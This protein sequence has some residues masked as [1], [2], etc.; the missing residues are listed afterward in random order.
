VI[1]YHASQEQF[2]PSELLQYAI[3]AEKAGFEAIHS[4]DHFHPWSKRQGNSGFTFAWVAA[5]MQA[6]TIPFGMICSPGQRYH[7]AIVAQAA[8][9]IEEMFPGRF[10]LELGSGEA[11]NEIITGDP[12]PN[13]Q[14]RN[15]RLLECNDIIRRLWN[16]ETVSYDGLVKI[17]EATLY[18]LPLKAPPLIGA[19]LS[20]AT[21]SWLG[22]WTDGLITTADSP[23]QAREILTAFRKG[24]GEGK[25]TYFKLQLSY[26]RS[27]ESA[28][29]G[30]YD[31]W[32]ANIL[33]PHIINELRSVPQ[34]DLHSETI[35]PNRM[36]EH[37][38]IS[39]NLNEHA[40]NIGRYIDL[41]F[42]HVILHNVNRLQKEF[43]EDFQKMMPKIT[44][45]L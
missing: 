32:R 40:D 12:W 19:A 31:Q 22:S 9:T 36:G 25:P 17:S 10:W 14:N 13:K 7:P 27:Y 28:L 37:L 6:T 2:A 18:T 8:A 42:D 3:L 1:I 20:V 21:A 24:G 29:E 34:I 30:A 15:R 23:E 26:A 41:G 11:L 44:R 38:L 45:H 35:D 5:A 43:I 39:A 33:P 4:S 16:G